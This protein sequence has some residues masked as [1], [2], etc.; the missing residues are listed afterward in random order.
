VALQTILMN[1]SD[2]YE[3]EGFS[4]EGVLTLDCTSMEGVTC[5]CDPESLLGLRTMLKDLTYNGIHWIDSGDYH[6]LTLLWIEKINRPF[7]LVLYDNHSDDQD[8][9]FGTSLLSCGSWVKAA[10]KLEYLEHFVHLRNNAEITIPE[11][12][13]V[14][15][16][17]DK[18]VLSHSYASTNWDQGTMTLEELKSSIKSIAATHEILG[19]D[20]CGELSI[21]QGAV[22]ID[23]K[24]NEVTN[25]IIQELLLNLLR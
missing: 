8:V 25:R 14:Y 11:G 19:A 24:T 10:R 20:V 2:V 17:I 4:P 5:Y 7:A 15:I 21:A 16:S 9:Q 12:L 6:Y 18:D 1:F 3:D 13:P 23:L 22:D